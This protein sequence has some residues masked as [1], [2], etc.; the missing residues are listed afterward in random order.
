MPI[1]V[2]QAIRILKAECNRYSLSGKCMTLSCVKRGMAGTGAT[3][4]ISTDYSISTCEHH[5]A[6]REVERLIIDRAKLALCET[7]R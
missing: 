2:S 5:E 7:K 1:A 6:V 4:P 3:F